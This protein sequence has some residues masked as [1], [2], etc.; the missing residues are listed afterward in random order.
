MSK[1]RYNCYFELGLDAISGKWKLLILYHL[2]E[3]RVLRFR[4]LCTLV[5]GIH[6]RVLTR[7]LRELEESK[8]IT[9]EIF[10]EVPPRV[11]YSLTDLGKT[12]IPLIQSLNNFGEEYSKHI[13]EDIFDGEAC[14]KSLES[15]RVIDEI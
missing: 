13:D 9:R 1:K 4:Q 10:P 5:S 15:F 7:Q 6:E 2:A 14:K 11:E 8:I 12:L 3:N